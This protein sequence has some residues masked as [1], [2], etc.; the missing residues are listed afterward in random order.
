MWNPALDLP[1]RVR[2]DLVARLELSARVLQDK[3]FIFSFQVLEPVGEVFVEALRQC[4][5]LCNTNLV[6][7]I[8]T[9]E[10][11]MQKLLALGKGRS[12]KLLA[13]R[14]QDVEDEQLILWPTS[15]LRVQKLS[16][17]HVELLSF[18]KER[19]VIAFSF[20]QPM[21]AVVHIR[22]T[23]LVNDLIPTGID[24]GAGSI[25]FGLRPE[26]TLL[27]EPQHWN[28]DLGFWARN[29][30]VLKFR[31]VHEKDQL[32]DHWLMRTTALYGGKQGATTATIA[33]R[34]VS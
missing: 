25:L 21:I 34:L 9:A 17:V 15:D 22:V 33:T 20:P 26:S 4:N 14:H 7:F 30:E 6:T 13:I 27:I 18:S 29:P 11:I 28:R 8:I 24:Q 10:A 19:V 1:A 32:A 12:S 23:G 16:A 5:P 3:P 2:V 31:I